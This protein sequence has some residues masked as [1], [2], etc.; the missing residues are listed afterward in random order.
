MNDRI[1]AIN[2]E[3]RLVRV[4]KSSIARKCFDHNLPVLFCPVNMD[5]L[6][7]VWNI[8]TWINNHNDDEFTDFDKVINSFEYYNCNNETGKYSAFYVPYYYVDGFGNPCPWYL[9][10][11]VT[12]RFLSYDIE[13]AQRKG[14]I[15]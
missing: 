6:N 7:K 1:F 14:I 5:P 11:G 9:S 4:Y 2:D 12:N 3:T 13:Y 15:S 10:E 8:G